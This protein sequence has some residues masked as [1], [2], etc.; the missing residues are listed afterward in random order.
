MSH[1]RG[2]LTGWWWARLDSFGV[3]RT[4]DDRYKNS[5][6]NYYKEPSCQPW[7]LNQRR[8]Y[9]QHQQEEPSSQDDALPST[10]LLFVAH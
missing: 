3:N 4:N 9:G 1:S 6:K 8:Y 5:A 7:I 10:V 2:L